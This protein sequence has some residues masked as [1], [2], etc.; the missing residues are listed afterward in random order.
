MPQPHRTLRHSSSAKANARY[1]FMVCMVVAPL[2]FFQMRYQYTNDK[3]KRKEKTQ[4]IYKI[5][6]GNL[7]QMRLRMGESVVQ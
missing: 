6:K 5:S 1:F 3:G 2:M 4:K 7:M